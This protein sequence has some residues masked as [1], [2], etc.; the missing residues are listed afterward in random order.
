M[1][2]TSSLRLTMTSSSPVVPVMESVVP[3]RETESRRRG[4][5]GSMKGQ[6]TNDMGDL[7][8]KRGAAG[9][10]GEPH[11]E[12]RLGRSLALPFRRLGRSLA[13]NAH[14]NHSHHPRI[15]EDHRRESASIS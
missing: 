5:K 6:C 3:P 11:S 12:T 10:E 8:G 1:S 14:A 15:D 2:L 9:L 4:S 13:A 7:L